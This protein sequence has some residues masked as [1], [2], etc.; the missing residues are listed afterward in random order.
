[1]IEIRSVELVAD[2]GTEI[3]RRVDLTIE[4]GECVA[5][6]VKSGAG[7]SS[8]LRL[9]NGLS[10]PT[11]GEVIVEGVRLDG[12]DLVALRRRIG[13]VI[14]Q[15]GLLPHLDVAENVAIVPR[16]L[17]WPRA[18]TQSRV[19]EVLSLVG[20]DPKRFRDRRPS[21]LSGGERQRVGVARALAAEPSIVLM[22]EPFGAVDPLIRGELQRDVDALR[23]KLG[24]TLVLV[25]HDVREAM[26]M[27]DRLV[28]IDE[29]TVAFA[30]TAAEL[31]RS[32]AKTAR[33]YADSLI[34]SWRATGERMA[35]GGIA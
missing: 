17:G 1:M 3:L 11:R 35:E 4:R 8:T 29:G 2:D 6:I 32:T 23:K 34:A 15:V 16:L 26:L 27:A 25:T 28:L 7:K 12:H 18:R 9:I 33:A 24:T 22:D 14:Q 5:L 30:G 13:Y 19:D 31:L 10:R 20:L 21:A